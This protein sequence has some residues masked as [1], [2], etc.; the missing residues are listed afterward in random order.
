MNDIQESTGPEGTT[1]VLVTGYAAAQQAL[2]ERRT[3]RFVPVPDVGIPAD[4]L[5]GMTRQMLFL[6]PP[7]HTRLRRLVSATFT[8]GR[9]ESMRPR[10]ERIAEE[11]LDAMAG[12]ETVDLL[13]A[14][15]WPLAT[16]GL[17]DLIGFPSDNA[18][19]F[20]TWTQIIAGGPDRMHEFP[21]QLTRVLTVI[22]DVL[23]ELRAH[24]GDHLLGDLIAASDGGERL[25]EDEL[26]SMVFGLMIAGPED[27]AHLIG[28]GVFRLLEERSRWHRLR[29][30]PHLLPT[31]IEEF[32]RY[33]PPLASAGNRRAVETFELGN[34]TVPAD[35]EIT[36]DL[37][38]ANR[39]ERRFPAADEL[40]LDREPNPHLSFGHGIHYCLGAPLARLEAHVAFTALLERF[41]EL[42]LAVPA[43]DLTWRQDF[44]T[45][46]TRLPVTGIH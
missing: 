6:D 1:A 43:G 19:E 23:A 30:E 36:V 13:D 40:R 16:R 37:A 42:R 5:S 20:R 25:S 4:V 35:A 9:I 33:D 14:Y 17:C 7:D 44:M 18:G 24:P 2:A 45:G 12:Q 15:A 34:R 21:A 10:I 39:D 31:A 11:L 41:P 26:S 22:R 3:T 32:L 29:A 27:V 28:N 38:Q 8:A 46:L